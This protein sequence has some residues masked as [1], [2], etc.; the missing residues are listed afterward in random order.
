VTATAA[1][2][3]PAALPARPLASLAI[4]LD[5]LW[6]YRRAIG[7]AGSTRHPSYL[8]R[9]VPTVL[10][11][12]DR[13]QL[14]ATFFIAGIDAERAEHVVEFAQIGAHDHEV[15]NHSHAHEPRLH[16]YGREELVAELVHAEDAITRATSAHPVGFRAPGHG[17]STELLEALAERGYLYD[18][19]ALPTGLGPIERAYYANAGML[20][21]AERLEPAELAAALHGDDGRPAGPFQWRLPSGRRLLE[22]PATVVPGLRTPFNLGYLLH[23]A[24][25][26]DRL[27]DTYL[28]AAVAAYR[29]TGAEP[30]LTV[31]PLDLLGGD[32]VRALAHLPGMDV[33]GARKVE[34]FRRVLRT[35]GERFDVVTMGT[36]AR[37]LLARPGLRVHRTDATREPVAL[38]RMAALV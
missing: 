4:D 11:S 20:N 36:H 16:R 14:K 33:S 10:A 18:A 25:S 29:L 35:V 8:G 19:S 27:V 31:H 13:L 30:V 1:P 28:R 6:V 2:R 5:D 32:Q 37:A 15:A 12:L 23:L 3:P 26:S 22:I 24:R 21:A 17:W 38:R 34:L 7:E 9:L